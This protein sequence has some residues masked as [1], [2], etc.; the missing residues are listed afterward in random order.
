MISSKH[1]TRTSGAEVTNIDQFGIWILL[2]D[3]EYFLPY[4]KFPW[5]RHVT[6]DQIITVE[7]FYAE[8]L[9]WPELD[10]DLSIESIRNPESFPL[11]YK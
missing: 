1:G 5:F 4:E 11:V 3:S 9:Y 6:V 7:T 10:I 2:S 8:H